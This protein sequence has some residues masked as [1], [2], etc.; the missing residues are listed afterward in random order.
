MNPAE[1]LTGNIKNKESHVWGEDFREEGHNTFHSSSKQIV[2]EMW[3]NVDRRHPG[4]LLDGRGQAVQHKY[5][6]ETTAPPRVHSSVR[7]CFQATLAL[8]KHSGSSVHFC[9]G[10]TGPVSQRDAPRSERNMAQ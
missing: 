7:G 2:R 5:W 6:D 3:S 9:V 8:L 10:E 4:L 1:F